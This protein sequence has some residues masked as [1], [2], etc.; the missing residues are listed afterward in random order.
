MQFQY[1][2]CPL[3]STLI[4]FVLH[5]G[6]FTQSS[7]CSLTFCVSTLVLALSFFMVATWSFIPAIK[8]FPPLRLNFSIYKDPNND[9]SGTPTYIYIIFY[10]LNKRETVI[11]I[12]ITMEIVMMMMNSRSSGSSWPPGKVQ[13]TMPKVE[14]YSSQIGGALRQPFTHFEATFKIIQKATCKINI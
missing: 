5:L 6:L 14:S 8:T 1:W 9:L 3:T 10:C 2:M 13:K 7:H 12:I 11:T 4:L